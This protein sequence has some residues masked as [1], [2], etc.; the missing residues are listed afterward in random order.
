MEEFELSEREKVLIHGLKILGCS[1]LQTMCILFDLDTNRKQIEMLEWMVANGSTANPEQLSKV[2]SQISRI[3][4]SG[5]YEELLDLNYD[6]PSAKYS[7]SHP[8]ENIT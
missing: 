7:Q 5:Y 3:C 4:D 8:D 2:S 6:S 1:L